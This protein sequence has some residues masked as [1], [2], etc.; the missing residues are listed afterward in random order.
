MLQ[1]VDASRRIL[2]NIY[3]APIEHAFSDIPKIDIHRA[4][5]H[6]VDAPQREDENDKTNISTSSPTADIDIF[7]GGARKAKR[8]YV[9]RAAA[10]EKTDPNLEKI[11]SSPSYLPD[12]KPYIEPFVSLC[13][14]Y[15][16]INS[17]NAKGI[18]VMPTKQALEEL[19]RD[20]NK[21]LGDIP[22]GTV[23]AKQVLSKNPPFLLQVHLWD[24]FGGEQANNGFPYA[25]PI[26]SIQH[27]GDPKVVQRHCRAGFK[28]YMRAMKP[29]I[30]EASKTP[31]MKNSVEWKVLGICANSSLFVYGKMLDFTP[32]SGKVGSLAGGSKPP[33]LTSRFTTLVRTT[34]DPNVAA[35]RFVGDVAIRNGVDK[36]VKYYSGDP[37]FTAYDILNNSDDF[38]QE[39]PEYTPN[40]EIAAHEQLIDN[41]N[42]SKEPI[43]RKTDKMNLYKEAVRTA[44]DASSSTYSGGKVNS[45][46]MSELTRGYDSLNLRSKYIVPDIACALYKSGGGTPESAL[47][48]LRYLQ[49]IRSNEIEYDKGLLSQGIDGNVTESEFQ[50]GSDGVR[51]K[52]K[53]KYTSTPFTDNVCDALTKCPMISRYVRGYI[54]IITIPNNNASL[55]YGAFE[56]TINLADESEDVVLDVKR[57]PTEPDGKTEIVETEPISSNAK[58]DNKADDGTTLKR[59]AD[60]SELSEV[61]DNDSD[62]VIGDEDDYS[63]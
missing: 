60:D 55:V 25:I 20:I 29:G 13:S 36:V 18:Y 12:Y 47:N 43:T 37:M 2:E 63:D 50:G 5:I 17:P 53:T 3:G 9:K 14:L 58:Q 16:L 32:Q 33:T 28:G 48:G 30:I 41:Y 62:F 21:L 11:F 27:G 7:A 56:D 10:T 8:K 54:P 34:A 6:Y 42:P 4:K 31:D 59:G 35:A 26:E 46:F 45:Q 51:P 22:P 38:E 1:T 19:K 39:L 40:Q 23:K 57:K 44:Y 24:Y 52:H 49:A 15:A 61:S